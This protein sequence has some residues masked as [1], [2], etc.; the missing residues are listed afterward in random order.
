MI[1][2]ELKEYLEGMES[3]IKAELLEAM[4]DMQMELL[5][6][7]AAHS[8]WM[9]LRVR[10]VEADQSNLDAALSGRVE[11]LEKRL[12]EIEQR[13]GGLWRRNARCTGWH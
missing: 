6:G 12:G 5:R 13:L 11:I 7:F 9:T 2:P 1:D 4:R 8:S 10:K 3:R